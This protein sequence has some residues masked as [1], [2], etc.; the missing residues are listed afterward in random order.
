MHPHSS[1][2]TSANVS[3][4]VAS[5]QRR[6]SR[7]DNE[8]SVVLHNSS[9]APGSYDTTKTRVSVGVDKETG[10][11][12]FDSIIT[13]QHADKKK[14]HTRF[15][16]LVAKDPTKVI[17]ERPSETEA[18]VVAKN[19]QSALDEII[20]G[21]LA[22]NKASIRN[23]GAVSR[24]DEAK[25]IRYVADENTAGYNAA[26][27]TRVIKM[28]QAQVDP[29][30]PPKFLHKKLPPPP[31]DAPVP[32]MHSPPRK[33][34]AEDHEAWRIPSCVSNWKNTRGYVIPLDKRVLSDGRNLLEP[35]INDNFA[36]L[37]ESLL[38][39]ERQARVEIET[40]AL[41][42]K[43]LA[44]KAKEEKEAELR[45]L[46]SKARLE[47]IG[48]TTS[49]GHTAAR[50]IE[51]MEDVM[52]AADFEAAS[53]HSLSSNDRDFEVQPSRGRDGRDSPRSRSSY[54]QGEDDISITRAVGES[55]ADYEARKERERRRLE[56]RKKL[57]REIRMNANGKRRRDEGEERDISEKIALGLPIGGSVTAQ[58]PEAMFDTRLFNQAE[59]ISSGFAAEDDYNVYDRAWRGGDSVTAASIYRPRAAANGPM[60]DVDAE[61]AV[62]GLRS[63]ATKRFRA[64]VDD[65]DFEGAPIAQRSGPVEF[66]RSYS[67]SQRSQAASKGEDDNKQDDDF[68]I[69]SLFFSSNA[70][71]K[72]PSKALLGI[73]QR[74][75]MAAASASR[76]AEELGS[77]PKRRSL[78]FTD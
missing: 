17:V 39:A 67:A 35:T 48:V 4:N 12:R 7:W 31:P 13:A 43:K 50:N 23:T 75:Q 10:E 40:R 1:S 3:G 73:G 57:E 69:D 2:V 74:G 22:S 61:A 63:A 14:V 56:H 44:M 20:S 15:G 11:A 49:S 9:G 24:A 46:A 30:E 18:L 45:S 28:V 26:T 70:T 21:K 54:R 5:N 58:N 62:S 6:A 25:I 47:R 34:T 76:T 71:T 8:T 68:E 52:Q 42:A 65:T 29:L 77:R 32:I 53:V 36:K 19:T 51:S 60:S 59:G 37:A 72:E 66:E 78:D 55:E 38:I 27:S 16:D 33:L 41:I 64:G